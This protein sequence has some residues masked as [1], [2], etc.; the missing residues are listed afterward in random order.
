MALWITLTALVLLLITG[1]VGYHFIEQF[2][3]LDA[4]YQTVITVTTVGF[5]EVHPLSPQGRI[6]T[7]FLILFGLGIVTYGLSQ[8]ARWTLEL[9]L[10]E[11]LGR[12]SV[13]T[14]KRL[15]GHY[16][17]CGHGRMGSAAAERLQMER[18]PFVVI[19]K[20][21]EQAEILK[22]KKYSFVIGDATD[23]E[24]LRTAGIQHAKGLAAL[25]PSDADN[26][27]LVMTARMLNPELIIVA[28]ALT[29]EAERKL[30]RAGANDVIA[31]YRVSGYRIALHMVNPALMD[32]VDLALIKKNLELEMRE[33]TV[34]PD[35]PIQGHSLEE[36]ELRKRANV[37]VVALKREG[38]MM[39]NPDPTLVFQPG[40][41]LIVLGEKKMLE[42]FVESFL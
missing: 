24:V 35:S 25:L 32:F 5:G 14:V 13:R 19:E 20:D 4:L 9:K 7:L 21:P 1:T 39:I 11:L 37:V 15:R 3:L 31:P 2:S 30:Y 12:R 28:R 33:Y 34:Q 17:I 18:V 22:E 38:E 27:Y 23:E 42:K 16:I 6:F 41:V 29:E 40:D 36:L 26:L 10:G 8:I